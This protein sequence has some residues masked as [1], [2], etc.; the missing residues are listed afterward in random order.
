MFSFLQ[1]PYNIIKIMGKGKKLSKLQTHV[2]YINITNIIDSKKIKMGL[3]LSK[4]T[5]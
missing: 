5:F 2:I 3:F 4:D 1:R